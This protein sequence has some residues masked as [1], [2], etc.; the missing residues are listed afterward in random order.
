MPACWKCKK[1]GTHCPGY[2]KS[3]DIR[4][5]MPLTPEVPADVNLLGS[6]LE[7][8]KHPGS[9]V[10][11]G[12]STRPTIVSV[13]QQ[14]EEAISI[15]A[16]AP[17][18]GP[19][20]GLNFLSITPGIEAVIKSP[21]ALRLLD[22][23]C[24]ALSV[25]LPWVDHVD[26][27]WRTIIVPAALR[28]SFL[29]NTILTM[30]TEDFARTSSGHPSAAVFK[31]QAEKYQTRALELL[32]RQL[33]LDV[34]SKN[35]RKLH[36][37][38]TIHVLAAVLLLCSLEM[39]KTHS[40]IWRVHLKAAHTL[41][42]SCFSTNM[43]SASGMARFLVLKCASLSVFASMSNFSNNQDDLLDYVSSS[44]EAEFIPFLRVLQS[45]TFKSRQHRTPPFLSSA[46]PTCSWA[47]C[48][49][50]REDLMQA[51]RKTSC[52]VLSIA[53]IPSSM[54]HDLEQVGI[55]FHLAGLVYG[56]QALQFNCCSRECEIWGLK[57]I[58]NCRAFHQL[59]L[60]SQD[61]LWPLFI[62]GTTVRGRRELQQRLET[63][64]HDV[65]TLSG[66]WNALS[67]LAFLKQFWKCQTGSRCSWIDFAVDWT[68]QRREFL[69]I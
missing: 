66:H 50:L 40:N 7:S 60:F 13:S 22:Y 54:R 65:A 47:G 20:S 58:D 35:A 5:T 68:E 2:R 6:G 28:S 67:A 19:W 59:S 55:M 27:P 33:A 17:V 34:A 42:R 10:G 44:D 38:E 4:W 69:V 41:I 52:W 64:I 46:S 14:P 61:I 15:S 48:A 12:L 8:A 31:I 37:E 56:H 11:R 45:I 57:I 23:Y 16:A 39:R 43:D 30:V 53:Q 26:N 63:E 21:D 3:T 25:R 32:S 1:K 18:P 49:T 9:E 36:S 24:N 51:R 62:A 29:L